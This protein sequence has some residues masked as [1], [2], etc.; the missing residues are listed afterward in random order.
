MSL[1]VRS[2]SFFRISSK[3]LS[4]DSS[5]VVSQAIRRL[6]EVF[7]VGDLPLNFIPHRTPPQFMLDLF[8][9][10]ADSNGI[11]RDPKI[12]EGNVVRSFEDRGAYCAFWIATVE[13]KIT[14]CKY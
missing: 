10:V 3:S 12:L 1:L 6:H 5:A 9:A 13:V 2:A 14:K 11:T 4:K 7:H 8:N